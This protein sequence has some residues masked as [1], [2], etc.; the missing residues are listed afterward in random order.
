MSSTN[1][2]EDEYRDWTARIKR[3]LDPADPEWFEKA[4]RIADEAIRHLT[5]ARAGSLRNS[6]PCEQPAAET[7]YS[8]ISA[9]Q[10]ERRACWTE[11]DIEILADLRLVPC[12]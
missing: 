2:F 10:R 1:S 4:Q 11:A 9:E 3:E 12:D 8:G 5:P 7:A 6:I